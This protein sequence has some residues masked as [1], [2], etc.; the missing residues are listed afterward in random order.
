MVI[1]KFMRGAS[2]YRIDG[3]A[4]LSEAQPGEVNSDDADKICSIYHNEEATGWDEESDFSGTC[5]SDSGGVA[6]GLSRCGLRVASQECVGADG[7][8]NTF[9]AVYGCSGE[10]GDAEVVQDVSYSEGN[11]GCFPARA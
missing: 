9:R 6:K 7:C 10:S 8:H 3:T 2:F 1:L 5:C 11:G 4:I